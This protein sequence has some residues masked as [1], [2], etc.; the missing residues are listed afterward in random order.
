MTFTAVARSTQ[1]PCSLLHLSTHAGTLTLSLDGR[2]NYS[3][4]GEGRP[5]GIWREEI[6]YRRALDNRVLAKWVTPGAARA[7][8][9]ARRFLDDAE[10]RALLEQTLGTAAA[11]AAALRSGALAI[12]AGAHDE[13]ALVDAWLARVAGWSW[14]RLEAEQARFAA[15]YR[16]IPIL[17]PDQYMSLVVQATEGCSYNECSFCT[18]YRDRPFRIKSLDALAAHT[19]GVLEL[20]GRGVTLRRSIFLA[21]ANAV[22]IAQN[23]LVPMLE[24]LNAALPVE[25]AELGPEQR[26]AWRAARPWS[27]DGHYA[28]ISAPDALHKSAADFA[29]LR[30]LGLRR[31]YVGVESGDDGLRSFLRKQGGAQQV[32]DAVKALKAGGLAVG[33]ILMVGVGGER[34]REAHFAHS[35][36][37]LASLPLDA[38]DLIYLSPFVASSDAPYAADMAAAAI[39]P[40]DETALLAEEERFR[41]A[42]GGPARRSGVKLSRYDI[43]EFV[44]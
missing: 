8:R 42:L 41:Q 22:V 18:F 33:L 1:S 27:L 2:Q 14:P 12:P 10:R 26:A 28:F 31:V 43:R 13:A 44:Y 34:F 5:V 6:T 29:E 15:V 17:P 35:C 37:L 25:P 7:T 23:R 24:Q 4:D 16:P 40:L 39:A 9:R 3:F 32:R 36:A 20:L 11:V 19:Q 38:G 30:A 21:D